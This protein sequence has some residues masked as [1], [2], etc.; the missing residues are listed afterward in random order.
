[1]GIDAARVYQLATTV[2]TFG[3]GGSLCTLG[4]PTL[5][6]TD[7]VNHGV[8][9][10]AGCPGGSSDPL[11]A[12]LG[13]THVESVDVSDFEGCTHIFD[14]NSRELPAPLRG[15]FDAVYNGGT[16]EH[17]FDIRSALRNIGEMLKEGGVVIHAGPVNGWVEHGFYQINPT[18]LVDY[19][20]ANRFDIL[21]GYLVQY[22][23][24]APGSVLVHPYMPGAFDHRPAEAYPGRWLFY[25]AFRKLAGSTTDAVPQQRSYAVIHDQTVHISSAPRLQRYTPPFRLDRGI[26]APT[27][28]LQRLLSAPVRMGGF[29]WVVHLP[30]LSEIA[31]TR[32]RNAASPLV[33]YEDGVP[34]GPPHARHDAIRTSGQG[35]YSHWQETLRFSPSRNDDARDHVYTVSFTPEMS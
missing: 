19:Y 28:T 5:R 34:I 23:P 31:N 25:M 8:L 11:F 12:R 30:E 4:V 24:D 16:L 29:E 3:A 13:F 33:L 10:A 22:L 35:R 26:P 6:D 1:M 32:G 14:L 18:L 21:E 7:A 17:I 27:P 20:F 15:Q 9:E 2:R